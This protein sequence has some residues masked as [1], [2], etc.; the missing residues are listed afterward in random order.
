MSDRYVTVWRKP[1]PGN[2]FEWDFYISESRQEAE[3]VV[4]NVIKQN[5]H[6][7][8]TYPLGERVVELSS[9]Y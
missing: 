5:V 6:Q 4:G 7:Y 8:G 9:E 1:A 3:R 2:I